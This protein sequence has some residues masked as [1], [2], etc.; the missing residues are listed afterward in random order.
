MDPSEARK[1]E[2]STAQL[3]R[4]LGNEKGRGKDWAIEKKEAA[5]EK[6]QG[7]KAAAASR[8]ETM[9]ARAQDGDGKVD[10]VSMGKAGLTGARAKVADKISTPLASRTGLTEDQ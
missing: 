2:A 5:T 7:G 9:K 8:V 10:L 4:E 6:L 3:L 1:S